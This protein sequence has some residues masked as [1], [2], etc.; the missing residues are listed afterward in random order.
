MYCD[1]CD[2]TT[3]CLSRTI[4]VTK[5]GREIIIERC[6]NC[7]SIIETEYFLG[8]TTCVKKAKSPTKG[9]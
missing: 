2:A 9:S 8:P 5:D 3:I 4:R 7:M 1:I 6:G